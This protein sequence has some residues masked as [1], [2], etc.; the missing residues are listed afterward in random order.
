MSF[1]VTP[2]STRRISALVALLAVGTTGCSGVADAIDGAKDGAKKVA[3][4]RSVFSL[5]TGDCYNPNTEPTDKA[6]QEEAAIEIVPCEEAHQGQVVGEFSI[7]EKKF[8]GDDGVSVIAD[9]RCPVEAQKFTPDTWALPKGV[10]V[11]YYH[12]TAESW[13][14]GDRSVSCSYTKE[15]GTFTGTLKSKPLDADQTAYLKGSNAV[16]DAFWTNQPEGQVEDDLPGYKAQ[17]EAVST[18]LK[19]HLAT[20]KDLEQPEAVALRARL[21][22]A[23]GGWKRAA[24]AGDTDSFYI[25]Y[26]LGFTGIDPN[27]TVAARKELGL[28]T[29]VPADDAEAWAP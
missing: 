22:K 15:S 19:A 21:E 25:A 16:Y 26:D 24:S 18:A 13:A 28:A 27:K 3:R 9:K 2:R 23:E 7:D 11:F 29:T 5:A 6:G 12:P 17:A 14:T 8:P 4:Q 10:S 1:G 20:L